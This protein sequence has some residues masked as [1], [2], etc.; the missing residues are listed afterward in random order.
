MSYVIKLAKDKGNSSDYFDNETRITKTVTSKTD[1][2]QTQGKREAFHTTGLS[3]SQ[4]NFEL[5]LAKKSRNLTISF[6]I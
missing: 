4:A 3:Q 5:Y 6:S 1:S 2:L